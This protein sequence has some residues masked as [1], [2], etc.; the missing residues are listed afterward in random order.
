[1]T[2]DNV[3]D[4]AFQSFES[5][6]SKYWG[7]LKKKK[8]FFKVFSHACLDHLRPESSC[9]VFGFE[10]GEDRQVQVWV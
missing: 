2:F 1:M 7:F 8:I 4:K 6:K 9:W 5:F 3:C 10:K